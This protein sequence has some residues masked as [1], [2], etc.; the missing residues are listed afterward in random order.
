M[1]LDTDK[2]FRG[3]LFSMKKVALRCAARFGLCGADGEEVA[4]DAQSDLFRHLHAKA[5]AHGGDVIAAWEEFLRTCEKPQGF[6]TTLALNAARRRRDWSRRPE[7]AQ[8]PDLLDQMN[9]SGHPGPERIVQGKDTIAFV[10]ARADADVRALLDGIENDRDERT[11]AGLGE[12]TRAKVRGNKLRLKELVRQAE[13]MPV[14][15]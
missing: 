7:L 14:T 6:R 15:T 9:E 12:T 10:Y 1:S 3:W 4:T 11:I 8:P 5:E 13:E 2:R